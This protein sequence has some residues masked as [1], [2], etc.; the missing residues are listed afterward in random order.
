MPERRDIVVTGAGAI[1]AAGEAAEVLG[2]AHPA[3]ARLHSGDTPGGGGDAGA[4][5]IEALAAALAAGAP[6]SGEITAFEPAE[7]EPTRA[8]E[9]LGFD[10][11]R[12]VPSI[13]SY[14]DRTSALALA[15]ARLALEDA[16]LLD[17]GSRGGAEVGLVYGTQW[18]CL[19]SM[20]IFYGKLRD[21][22]PRFAPPL[23]FSHSYANSTASV[24][25]IELGL[26]GHHLVVSTGRASGAWAILAGVDALALGRARAIACAASDSF[27]RAAFRLYASLGLLLPDGA[28]D[29]AG[30]KQGRF[31]L[32]EGAGALI[33]EDR[34]FAEARGAEV[35]GR[36]RGAEAARG[37]DARDACELAA[38]GALARAGVA[39]GEVTAIVGTSPSGP[40]ARAEAASA[41]AALEL[42]A[43]AARDIFAPLGLVLGETMAAS[44]VLAAACAC[45]S[46]RRAGGSALV[47]CA[48]D[49]RETP[50]REGGTGA[51]AMVVS[52]P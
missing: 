14:I 27:S 29:A 28:A 18:G 6:F 21:G 31:L 17:E 43:E 22:D 15:A 30:D 20:E 48:E 36:L 33:L 49:G 11:S 46:A 3:A 51:V 47:L 35:R 25:A 13:K 37:A 50:G 24:L 41:G 40:G 23:P 45:M 34:A 32:G 5:T 12:H 52:H 26:R 16:R 8:A 19:D 9:I 38:R 39:P 10:L 44:G 1:S 4:T 2:C 42:R 7:G